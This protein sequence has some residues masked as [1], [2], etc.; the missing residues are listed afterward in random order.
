MEYSGCTGLDFVTRFY[1]KA[2]NFDEL[3]N[4]KRDGGTP[5]LSQDLR[6]AIEGWVSE[7]EELDV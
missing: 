2:A 3:V 1:W 4:L 6:T 5:V 7:G